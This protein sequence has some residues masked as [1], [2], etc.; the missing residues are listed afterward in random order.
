MTAWT[1]CGVVWC[2]VQPDPWARRSLEAASGDSSAPINAE[3][4]D[5]ASRRAR[6]ATLGGRRKRTVSSE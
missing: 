5:R 2:G 1:G 3:P 6:A 4:T